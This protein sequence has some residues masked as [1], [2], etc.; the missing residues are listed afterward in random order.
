PFRAV[1]I[2]NLRDMLADS[3]AIEEQTDA[4]LSLTPKPGPANTSRPLM[5]GTPKPSVTTRSIE[6]LS[7]SNSSDQE[8]AAGG[9]D[10]EERCLMSSSLLDLD[11]F[12]AADN[13]YGVSFNAAASATAA[14]AAAAQLN[15]N[16][17]LNDSLSRSY[18]FCNFLNRSSS[19]FP[20]ASRGQQQSLRQLCDQ[21]EALIG[22]RLLSLIGRRGGGE[23][24]VAS[25]PETAIDVAGEA[26]HSMGNCSSV[27]ALASQLPATGPAA[28]LLPPD[29]SWPP[30]FNL[31]PGC[32]P[33]PKGETSATFAASGVG[34]RLRS[35]VARFGLTGATAFTPLLAKAVARPIGQ[36]AAAE[37]NES[38]GFNPDGRPRAAQSPDDEAEAKLKAENE[39]SSATR[40][41]AILQS[42]QP[43]QPSCPTRR[44]TESRRYYELV[45]PR[46]ASRAWTYSTYLHSRGIA[47]R[48]L[49]GRENVILDE[50]FC[51]DADRISAAAAFVSPDQTVLAA[52]LRRDA[53]GASDSFRAWHLQRSSGRPVATTNAFNIWTVTKFERAPKLP[54]F[55]MLASDYRPRLASGDALECGA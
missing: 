42:R 40:E 14:A 33:P 3:S 32:R 10:D 11:E 6:R 30:L 5:L 12:S 24:S 26:V 27:G 20:S 50:R 19:G 39:L 36:A 23:S 38:V 17:S 21:T 1:A 55:S 37:V 29:T 15:L 28:R 51:L 16:A 4:Q 8:Q 13:C 25:V 22:R 18:A 47:H 43:P 7:N 53:P 46:T 52:C 45:M 2:L 34:G 9:C 49:K 31:L 54:V 48:D 35:S 41:A 44:T